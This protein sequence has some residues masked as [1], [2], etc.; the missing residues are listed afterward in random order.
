[1]VLP[2]TVGYPD[3]LNEIIAG[4]DAWRSNYASVEDLNEKVLEVLDE[5]AS[6]GQVLRMNGQETRRRYTDLVKDKPSEV[7]T[8]RV[9][10]GHVGTTS[11]RGHVCGTKKVD[12][13]C[14]KCRN[15]AARRSH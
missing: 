8:A 2:E 10:T 1:M 7:V 12:Q 5:P 4:E 15:T 6:R 9:L 11:T 13:R 14:G 3:N